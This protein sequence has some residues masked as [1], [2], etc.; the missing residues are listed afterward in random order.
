MTIIC[1]IFRFLGKEFLNRNLIQQRSAQNSQHFV[2]TPV[3][4]EVVLNDSHHAICS[5]GRVYLDSDSSLCRT[6]KGLDFEMLFNPFKEEFYTPTI[7]VEKSDLRGRYLHIVGQVDKCLVLVSRIVC[8]AT[9]DSRIFLFGEVIRKSY[10]LVREYAICVMH[11]VAFVNNFIL[12]ISSLPYHKIGSR[13]SLTFA[14]L[15]LVTFLP[16]PR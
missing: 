3:Q 14:R 11:S 13:L 9:K 6:P 2:G 12:K 16:K 15:L 5:D 4:S 7:F 1:I 10:N 8:D